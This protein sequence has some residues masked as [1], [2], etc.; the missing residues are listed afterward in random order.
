MQ[1]SWANDDDRKEMLDI[2]FDTR[3]YDMG[4]LYDPEGVSDK[5]LRYTNTGE[6]GV[7]SFWEGFSSKL[8]VAIENLN[9]LM[10]K[11]ND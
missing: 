6:T 7:V 8:E 3:T 4:L 2:I 1:M 10:Y 9:E 5:V 11:Y